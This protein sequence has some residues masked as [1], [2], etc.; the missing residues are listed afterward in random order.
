MSPD[1]RYTHTYGSSYIGSE[2]Q[3]QELSVLSDPASPI[4]CTSYTSGGTGFNSESPREVISRIT[5]WQDA[6]SAWEDGNQKLGVNVPLRMWKDLYGNQLST[7]E[8]KKI[9]NIRL[10]HTEYTVIHH[11]DVESFEST[12]HS[13]LFPEEDTSA[14]KHLINWTSLLEAV[15]TARESRGEK[16]TRANSSR[17]GKPIGQNKF[18]I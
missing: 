10:V 13:L 1:I 2:H 11:R 16:K 12:C 15:N 7:A 3:N 6:I 5:D 4:S 14:V 9:S 18:R 8:Q 17:A